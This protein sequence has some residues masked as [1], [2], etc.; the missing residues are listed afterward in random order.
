M[1]ALQQRSSDFS[2]PLFSLRRGGGWGSRWE[3][4]T[5]LT[6]VI[7]INFLKKETYFVAVAHIIF[8]SKEDF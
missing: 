2:F 1:H 6:E 4:H 7:F 8:T 5:K 3:L